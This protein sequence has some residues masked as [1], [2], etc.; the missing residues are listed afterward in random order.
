MSATPSW[1]QRWLRAV[2]HRLR[3]GREATLTRA[4]LE[5]WH[6]LVAMIERQRPAIHGLIS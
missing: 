4:Q 3:T 5:G 1:T 2:A 6:G